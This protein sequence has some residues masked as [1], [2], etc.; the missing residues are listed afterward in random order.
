MER[1]YEYKNKFSKTLFEDF[2]PFWE[3]FSPDP[4]YGGFL[5]GF[6]RDGELF[7]EDKSVWQQGR[8]LWMFSKLY[9]EFEKNPKWLEFARSG[10]DF[11]NKYCFDENG[12]M[13]F[14]VTRDGKPLINRRYYFSEAFAIMG[15]AEFYIAVKDEEVKQRAVDLFKKMFHY[16]I[17][18][19]CFPPKVNPKTRSVRTH[20]IVMIMLC[21]CQHMRKIDDSPI[22]N[23]I[24][25]A[26]ISEITNNF[27][28]EDEKALFE[29]VGAHGERLNSPEGRL[30]N[31]GHSMETAWFLM[32]EAALRKDAELMKK[33]I[34]ITEWSFDIGWD[35]EMGG[36]FYF[37]DIENKPVLSLEWDMKLLWPHCEALIAFLRS[38]MFM[39]QE[40]Y[41]DYFDRITEYIYAHF[42]DPGHPEWFGHL[43]R[44]GTPISYIK[45]SDWKGPYHNVRAFMQIIELLKQYI[46]Y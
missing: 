24:I 22:Y 19:G 29:T 44:D 42:P 15:Y 27:V 9:N 31:P 26:C 16:Y 35:K 18:P 30:I 40:K 20:S 3:K 28:K 34:Q 13:Y 23:T 4:V 38:Y 45:G 25:D 14:K 6:D 32:E 39:G 43:H 10:Y 37:R 46:P 21:V 41:L 36:I 2:I 17:T 8:S 11:I 5:C 33:A 7:F 1:L 12:H